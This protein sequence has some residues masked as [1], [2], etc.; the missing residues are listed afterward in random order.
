[1]ASNNPMIHKGFIVI[2]LQLSWGRLQSRSK[3]LQTVGRM[4]AF[5]PFTGIAGAV[6]PKAGYHKRDSGE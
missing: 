3:T 4:K 1:M 6:M 2:E 5:Q